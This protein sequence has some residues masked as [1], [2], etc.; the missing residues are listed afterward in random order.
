MLYSLALQT[1]TMA[2]LNKLPSQWAEAD[3]RQAH[4]CA[5]LNNL[6]YSSNSVAVMNNLHMKIE[7]ATI[8]T[9]TTITIITTIITCNRSHLAQVFAPLY[10]S[11]VAPAQPMAHVPQPRNYIQKRHTGASSQGPYAEA[12]ASAEQPSVCMRVRRRAKKA[13]MDKCT[14][15]QATLHDI[16]GDIQDAWNTVF[17]NSDDDQV[18]IRVSW[19]SLWGRLQGTL[20]AIFRDALTESLPPS[21]MP[22]LSQASL[23]NITNIIKALKAKVLHHHGETELYNQSSQLLEYFKDLLQ[24]TLDV[25]TWHRLLDDLILDTSPDPT[26]RNAKAD[27]IEENLEGANQALRDIAKGAQELVV[28]ER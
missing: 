22:V 5:A 12:S 7:F 11:F 19:R 16:S 18:S 28:P 26:Y 21:I 14:L 24:A 27:L 17:R 10:A 25:S 6:H 13:S 3:Q 20:L 4:P 15:Y 8:T 2:A 9:M 23:T 1:L